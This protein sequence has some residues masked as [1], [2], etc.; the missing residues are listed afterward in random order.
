MILA[1]DELAIGAEHAGII[2]LAENGGPPPGTPLEEVLPIST[3]V[4]EFEIT[5]N[6]PDCLGV[7]GIAREAHAATGAALKPPPWAEDLGP[8]GPVEGVSIT[9]ESPD[10]CP[11]FTARVFEDVKI[12]PSPPWLK[13]RLMAAGQ[14]PI[15][16]VVDITNYA[17]LLTGQPLHAFDLDRIAGHR[18]DRPPRGRRRAGADPRRA[19]AHARRPDAP[20]RR[21]RGADLD[22]GRDG[23]RPLR[24]LRRHHARADGGGDL[25]RPD[26]PPHRLDARAPERGV[27]AV[28]EAA[29]ARAGDRGAGG[30]DQADA[31]G[32]RGNA[33]GRDDRHRWR[34][35]AA[36]DDPAPGRPRRRVARRPDPAAA[37]RRDPA[38]A[39]VRH[40]GGGGRP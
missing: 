17:M 24:G 18:P 38:L 6:R 22:R 10:L 29:P 40:R 5:S 33:Q 9:V 4:L 26:H 37:L 15:S 32:V 13:A 39:R 11:R 25:G 16:N 12:G 28:R 23:R 1:E 31:R 7:Y 3:E 34:R 20:D 8:P 14:R 21:R 27:A 36:G 35:P 30:R 2:V 19:D